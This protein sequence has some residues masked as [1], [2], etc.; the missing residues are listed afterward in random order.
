[1]KLN[2]LIVTLSLVFAT[3]TI[4]SQELELG[5]LQEN[6][7]IFAGIV[8]E[9]LGLDQ[10]TGLFGM[11]LGGV[12]TM[13]FH[14]QGAVLEIRTPLANRRNQMTIASINRAM[15]TLNPFTPANA[16]GSAAEASEIAAT[17]VADESGSLYQDMMD[18]I[19]NVDYSLIVD[20]AIQQASESARS[21][22]NAGSVNETDYAQLQTELN[23]LRAQTAEKMTEMRELMA[24]TVAGSEESSPESNADVQ[25]MFDSFL[26]RVEP[27]KE[28]ALAKAAE[29]KARSE[30]AQQQAL[31]ALEEE[32][33]SFETKLFTT[34]CN[35]GATLRELPA[36]EALSIVLEGL[37]DDAERSNRTDKV[38]IIAKSDLLACQAGDIDAS[39]LLAQS[40]TYSY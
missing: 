26:A 9:S 33:I 27:L 40:V 30:Q 32:I 24:S 6:I 8:E 28:Q 4:R 37:G 16:Q 39:T 25:A 18:R 7:D 10:S 29:L 35:Y 38:H 3:S 17:A 19:A 22:R 31:A 34:L 23:E 1:M 13:Y 15:L 14:G 12:D 2:T 20:S 5:S 36:N 11:S 21:L